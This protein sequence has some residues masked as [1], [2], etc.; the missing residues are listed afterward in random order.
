MDDFRNEN[1][2]AYS[3][4]SGAEFVYL[5]AASPYRL[6]RRRIPTLL[7]LAVFSLAAR[8]SS[9]TVAPAQTTAQYGPPATKLL[10]I[11]TD[12]LASSLLISSFDT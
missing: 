11:F 7:L 4:Y 6:L 12:L 8:Y 10:V 1:M 5:D 9:H 2:S 3:P